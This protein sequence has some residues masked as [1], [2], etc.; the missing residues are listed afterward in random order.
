MSKILIPLFLVFFSEKE[1][2]FQ[3]NFL[4][5]EHALTKA[6]SCRSIDQSAPHEECP[7]IVP[8]MYL[9][10]HFMQHP[11]GDTRSKR[12]TSSICKSEKQMQVLYAPYAS[13]L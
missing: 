13:M 3:N 1:V 7:I 11:L 9:N 12:K 2:S 8:S 10:V 4:P 6:P 5:R